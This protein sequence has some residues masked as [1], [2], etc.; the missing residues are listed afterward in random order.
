MPNIKAGYPHSTGQKQNW[1]KYNGGM[2]IY[3][4]IDYWSMKCRHWNRDSDSMH[5]AGGFAGVVAGRQNRQ[6][7]SCWPCCPLLL[8]SFR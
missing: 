6:T 4:S 7:S 2:E 1:T 3:N 5:L 8:S